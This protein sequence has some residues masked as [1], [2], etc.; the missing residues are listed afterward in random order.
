[1]V[2]FESLYKIT[3]TK[4]QDPNNKGERKAKKIQ[5]YKVVI[6]WIFFGLTFCL[7]F[8]FIICDLLFVI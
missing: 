7:S 3:R 5:N 1:M 8:A 6:G 4:S 2:F